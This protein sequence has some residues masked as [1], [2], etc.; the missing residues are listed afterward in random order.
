MAALA[1]ITDIAGTTPVASRAA[2]ERR[3]VEWVS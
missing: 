1:F 2:P 3:L